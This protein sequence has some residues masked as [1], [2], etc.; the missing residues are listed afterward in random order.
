MAYEYEFLRDLARQVAQ[1]ALS[2]ENQAKRQLWTRHNSLK[3]TERP[4]VLCLP[5]GGWEELVPWNSLQSADPLFRE[6]EYELRKRLYKHQIGDDEVIEPWV[7]IK[8]VHFGEDRPMMWGVNID[9]VHSPAGGAFIFKPEINEES[10]IEKLR[11]PDWRVDEKTTREKY[12]K[13][14]ELL[15]NILDVKIRYGRLNDA[16]LAYWG[17]YLRGLE[18]MMY[19][20]LDRPEWFRRFIKFLSD[21]HVK[22]LKGLEAENHLSRN[23]IGGC[24]KVCLTCEDLPKAGFDPRYVRL[25]DTWCDADSQEFALVSP[26]LWDEFLLE[27]QL[28]LLQAHGLVAYGCC[29]SLVGKLEIL[30]KK[31]PNL[32][33]VTVSPWS[34]I[35]YSAEQCRRDVVMQIRPMPTDVLMRFDEDGMRKDF[36]EKM[37]RAGDT[38]YDFCLQDIET[39]YGRP[40]VLKTWT[41]IAKQVGAERYH[42]KT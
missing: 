16:G 19:D 38:I 12:E 22:H 1:I 9:V 31:V 20:C 42:R 34:N 23:D 29:E 13:T 39:V 5:C 32:R 8:A 35:E 40:E 25:L 18:R 10:D 37:E 27:Y 3:K 26:R 41:R 2:E 21:A 4:P 28:P 14:S 36:E 15:K 30:R 24:N 17:A 11:V 7:E 6:I 33:R